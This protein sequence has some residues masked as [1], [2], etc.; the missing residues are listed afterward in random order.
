LKT[1]Q[2]DLLK[3]DPNSD[4]G[5]IQGIPGPKGLRASS[6]GG[7]LGGYF[8]SK[9]TIKTEAELLKI[10]GFFDK[11]SSRE[12]MTIAY[13]GIKDVD[14]KM[15]GDLLVPNPTEMLSDDTKTGTAAF[16]ELAVAHMNTG[17]PLKSDPVSALVGDLVAANEK[18][19]VFDVAGPLIS[20]TKTE[21]GPELDKIK[22]DAT[23]K[24]IMGQIDEAGF[25]KAIEDWKKA[26]GDKVIQELT[27]EYKK[28][29]GK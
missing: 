22:T 9:S 10:L 7:T 12:G 24:F 23:V 8:F 1:Y 21:K 29:Q 20:P 26:G 4:V 18:V 28:A 27:A 25:K 16:R 13:R 3:L 5:F 6:T 17:T 15:E 2:K 19:A 14:Y 11:L